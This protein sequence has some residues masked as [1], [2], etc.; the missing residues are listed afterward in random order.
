[1]HAWVIV[2]ED[3]MTLIAAGAVL[4]LLAGWLQV[5]ASARRDSRTKNARVEPALNSTSLDTEPS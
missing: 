4:G 2:Q 5:I 3:E 1:M